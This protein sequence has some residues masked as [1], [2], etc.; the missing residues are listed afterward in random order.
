VPQTRGSR[1]EG[2]STGNAAIAAMT[3]IMQVKA[4]VD[5]GHDEI[6]PTLRVSDRRWSE[7]SRNYRNPPVGSGKVQIQIQ[8]VRFACTRK[9]AIPSP[10][11]GREVGSL[12]IPMNRR[13]PIV[14]SGQKSMSDGKGSGNS[15]SPTPD[16]PQWSAMHPFCT[17]ARSLPHR[18][19]HNSDPDPPMVTATADSIFPTGTA[20]TGQRRFRRH[21]RFSVGH[22]GLRRLRPC[23]LSARVASTDATVIGCKPGRLLAKTSRA[24]AS[25]SGVLARAR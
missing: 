21:S 15:F 1:A 14:C 23:V 13:R 4:R 6:P 8:S 7:V 22:A 18:D 16:A 19:Q 3:R 9:L 24:N 20:W 11:P 2:L 12:P 10:I 25:P 17:D 5:M